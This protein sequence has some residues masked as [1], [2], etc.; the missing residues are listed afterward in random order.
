[1]DAS[2]SP[3]KLCI[4]IAT[5]VTDFCTQGGCIIYLVIG[6]LLNTC[7]WYLAP[8]F[9]RGM[10]LALLAPAPTLA[11]ALG[12]VLPCPDLTALGSTGWIPRNSPWDEPR[13]TRLE[14]AGP[15][16]LGVFTLTLDGFPYSIAIVAEGHLTDFINGLNVELPIHNR[17]GRTEAVIA[18]F[19]DAVPPDMRDVPY[20]PLNLAH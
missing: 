15:T 20:R 13:Q 7:L 14:T 11:S 5:C 19:P 18:S 9:D 2:H 16:F 1:M 12:L 8:T 3:Q 4:S 6:S 10:A 17:N